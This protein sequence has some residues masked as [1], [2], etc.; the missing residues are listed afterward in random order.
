VSN[1]C[2]S[3]ENGGEVP[4]DWSQVMYHYLSTLRLLDSGNSLSVGP[5][6]RVVFRQRLTTPPNRRYCDLRRDE[7]KRVLSPLRQYW[8]CDDPASLEGRKRD[9]DR[10][11][12]TFLQFKLAAKRLLLDAGMLRALPNED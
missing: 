9:P 7:V 11:L 4:E 1:P 5:G 2:R 8:G 3:N 12:M 10:P 6:R